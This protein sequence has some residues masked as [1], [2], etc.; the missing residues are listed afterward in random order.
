[1]SSYGNFQDMVSLTFIYAEKERL[2]ISETFFM[3]RSG[4]YFYAVSIEI[5]LL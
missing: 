1:M 4:T 5:P 3:K 2:Q